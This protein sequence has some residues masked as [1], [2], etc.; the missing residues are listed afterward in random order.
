MEIK[1]EAEQENDPAKRELIIKMVDW[2]VFKL[3]EWHEKLKEYENTFDEL[4]QGNGYEDRAESFDQKDQLM[5]N[6]FNHLKGSGCLFYLYSALRIIRSDGKYWE[7][8]ATSVN[9]VLEHVLS[10]IG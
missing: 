1:E 10:L 7:S 4:D 6:Y 3:E 5:Q 8:D 9:A 2:L